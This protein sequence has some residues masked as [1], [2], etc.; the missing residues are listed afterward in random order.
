K[1]IKIDGLMLRFGRLR[2]ENLSV[3]IIELELPLDEGAQLVAFRRRDIAVDLS[4]MHHECRGRQPIIIHL[5]MRGMRCALRNVSDKLAEAFEHAAS[6]P[7]RLDLAEV[8]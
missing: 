6:L 8:L 5:E 3:G 2:D 1:M 4:G 7:D